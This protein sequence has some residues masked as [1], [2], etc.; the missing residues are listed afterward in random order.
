MTTRLMRP[1]RLPI[2]C[3]SEACNS[4]EFQDD[5][6]SKNESTARFDLCATD[7]HGSVMVPGLQQRLRRHAGN[8]HGALSSTMLTLAAFLFSILA[9]VAKVAIDRRLAF[10]LVEERTRLAPAQG[11]PHGAHRWQLGSSELQLSHGRLQTLD[12]RVF[13]A[14]RGRGCGEPGRCRDAREAGAALGGGCGGGRRA[15]GGRTAGGRRGSR[16]KDRE[17]HAGRQLRGRNA[18]AARVLA[19]EEPSPVTALLDPLGLQHPAAR[20]ACG[21]RRWPGPGGRNHRGTHAQQLAWPVLATLLRARHYLA[22]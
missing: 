14:L 22:P 1:H 4:S 20:R 15:A 12:R 16:R 9:D 11:M 18:G 19:R 3:T 17:H 7:S 2:S 6:A 10:V 21:W 13:Q 5:R 8:N